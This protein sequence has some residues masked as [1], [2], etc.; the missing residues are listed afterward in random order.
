M[1]VEAVCC[2]PRKQDRL[3]QK[4]ADYETKT[5]LCAK[6]VFPWQADQSPTLST[7]AGQEREH[8]A[9]GCSLSWPA[10][11]LKRFTVLREMPATRTRPRRFGLRHPCSARYS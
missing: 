7:G 8:P 1:L 6:R 4:T 2:D 11:V 5:G 3:S 10:P 9:A